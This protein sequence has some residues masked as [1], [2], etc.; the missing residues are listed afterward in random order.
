MRT[1]VEDSPREV[2]RLRGKLAEW[3]WEL[4][5]PTSKTGAW[6]VVE[7]AHSPPLRSSAG[8]CALNNDGGIL[9]FGG[10]NG[11]HSGSFM[12]DTWLLANGDWKEIK[13]AVVPGARSNPQLVPY[14]SGAVMFGGFVPDT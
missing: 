8:I 7:T 1:I 12:N 6:E 13:P 9:V 14:K 3:D 2:A 5:S 10:A 4:G 11:E